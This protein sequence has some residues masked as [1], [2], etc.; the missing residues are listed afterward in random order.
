M[1]R[2]R[3]LLEYDGAPYSGWQRQN[4]R[5]SVQG[6]IENAL[7]ALG[8]ETVVQGAG[9]TDAGVHATGQV[10]HVDCA[11]D[12]EPF[13]LWSAVNAHLKGERIA[14]LACERVP[15]EWHARFCAT[16]RHYRY[17]IVARRPPLTLERGRAWN[18]KVPLDVNAMNEAARR[19]VGTH[20]FSTFRSTECQAR[21]PVRT[22][23]RLA[24]VQSGELIEWH[25]SARSFLHNQVRSLVGSLEWVGRGRW[26]ADDL[27]AALLARDRARCGPVAPAH[28]LYLSRVDY[29]EG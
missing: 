1:S 12:W 23:D 17:R 5:P 15:N 11:R 24:A 9:R 19:L 20:D 3:L 25:V 10:A 21:S 14:V 22:L 16:A 7:R 2:F 6:A 4:D 13:K 18:S 26:G 29:E 27:E 8:E 28:G